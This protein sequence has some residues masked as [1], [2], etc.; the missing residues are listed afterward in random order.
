MQDRVHT[1]VIVLQAARTGDSATAAVAAAAAAAHTA[2]A[3]AVDSSGGGA[4]PS[5]SEAASSTLRN[6]VLLELTRRN[7]P[8]LTV[9]PL[10]V[11]RRR[12]LLLAFLRRSHGLDTAS[13]TAA[14][15]DESS[16]D[17]SDSSRP[18]AAT[19]AGVAD[20][21]L[22]FLTGLEQFADSASADEDNQFD[23]LQHGW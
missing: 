22:T 15:N 10:T 7:W 23:E 21:D 3:A 18:R 17:S 11:T 13:V 14:A 4:A 6:K 16:G 9:Q 19:T 12:A 8:M 20:T 1:D 5:N 2:A